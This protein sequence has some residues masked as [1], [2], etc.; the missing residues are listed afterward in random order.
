MLSSLT[1]RQAV[2]LLQEVARILKPG[3]MI[4]ICDVEYRIQRPGPVGEILIN[5]RCEFSSTATFLSVYL[6]QIHSRYV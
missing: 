6:I 5:Q 3:G 1:E 4:E 2:S